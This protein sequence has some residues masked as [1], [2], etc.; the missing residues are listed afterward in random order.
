MKSVEEIRIN[1][2]VEQFFIYALV[3]IFKAKSITYHKNQ[4]FINFLP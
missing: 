3:Y 1:T 2:L 4:E